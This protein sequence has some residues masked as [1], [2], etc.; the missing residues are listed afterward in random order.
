LGT[1]LDR[2]ENIGAGKIGAAGFGRILTHISLRD[3]PFI[4]ETPAENE[5]DDRRDVEALK[6]LGTPA[7]SGSGLYT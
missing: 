6:R 5:G 3:K 2:H 7:A 4:L 1:H